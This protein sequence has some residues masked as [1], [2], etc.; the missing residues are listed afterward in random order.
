LKKT[1]GN[2][3]RLRNSPDFEKYAGILGALGTGHRL[4]ILYH[5]L[6]AHPHGM[7]AGEIHAELGMRP[8]AVSHHLEKLKTMNLVRVQREGTFLRYRANPH[9]LEEL[10]SF[11]VS[12]CCANSQVV[13]PES[14][15]QT[16]GLTPPVGKR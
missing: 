4:R 8:S 10:L 2:A 15:L 13:H 6:R 12:Q 9:V 1:K 5:L 14:V 16:C 3:A 7:V 11:L